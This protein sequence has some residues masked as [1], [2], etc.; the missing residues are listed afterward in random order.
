MAVLANGPSADTF[1]F[2]ALR[3]ARNYRHALRAEFASSLRGR[4]VE[5]GAGIGQMTE[6]LVQAPGTGGVLAVEPDPGYCEQ[7]RRRL[8]DQPLIQGTVADLPRDSRG[9]CV[10]SINVLEHI[11]DD[12]RELSEYARLLRHDSGVLC[13]FV[14]ARPEIYA[15]IEEGFGHFRRYRRHELREKLE[16]AGFEVVR[17]H[18]F[19]VFGYFAW[20]FNFCFLRRRHFDVAAVRFFDSA[21]FPT[22]HALESR[23]VRPPFGQSLLAIARSVR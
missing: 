17:L 9:D 2:E 15:P 20:W 22:V 21:I 14:P 4:I 16:R 6:L 11:A 23:V 7:F 13:L 5:V 10:V 12:E 19:N 18:Y 1:E 8:P 3:Y